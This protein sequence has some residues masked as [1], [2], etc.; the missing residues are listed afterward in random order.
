LNKIIDPQAGPAMALVAFLNEHQVRPDTSWAIDE[1]GVLRG[2]VYGPLAGDMAAV[3]WFAE[4]L[5]CTPELRH[6]YEYAGRKLQVL[7]L[8]ALWRDVPVLVEVSV[9]VVLQPTEI[10]LSDGSTFAIGVAA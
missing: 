6:Q 7:A 3:E 5:G 2:T 1:S 10:R 9:P 4:A 8:S